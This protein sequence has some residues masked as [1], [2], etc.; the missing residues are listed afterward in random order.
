[1]T[2]AFEHDRLAQLLFARD[3]EADIKSVRGKLDGLAVAL[4]ID[5]AVQREPWAQAAAMAIVACGARMFRGGVFLLLSP[6]VM[7]VLAPGLGRPLLRTLETL[8]ARRT[9]GP[10]SHAVRLHIG[11]NG[12][13]DLNVAVRGWTALISPRPIDPASVKSNVIAGVLAGSMAIS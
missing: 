7:T 12:A 2:I 11:F 6:H 5:P 8:G 1:M 13:G 3:E 9:G 10:P 4:T